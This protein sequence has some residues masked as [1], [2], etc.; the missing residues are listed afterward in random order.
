MQCTAVHCSA[1]QCFAMCCSVLQ[2]VAVCCI[3]SEPKLLSCS[4]YVQ[5]FRDLVCGMWHCLAITTKKK[6]YAWGKNKYGQLGLGHTNNEHTPCS[7]LPLS[8]PFL[9]KHVRSIAA[10]MVTWFR[11]TCIYKC[12]HAYMY[13]HIYVYI[14]Y[15]HIYISYMY[16]YTDVYTCVLYTYDDMRGYASHQRAFAV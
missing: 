10:G 4:L 16:M 12:I 8:D 6:V 15:I 3:G 13:T 9:H 11:H 5:V 7:I 14:I 1:L 2:C